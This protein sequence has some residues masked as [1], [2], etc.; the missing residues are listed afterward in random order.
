[1]MR[2]FE[3]DYKLK[4]YAEVMGVSEGHFIRSFKKSTGKTP[5]EYRACEQIEYA[6]TLLIETKLKNKDV[7]SLAGFPDALYFSRVFRKHTGLSPSKFRK[8][9]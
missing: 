5:L 1:M 4:D 2:D 9:C 7:A 6:K 3:R 8:Q